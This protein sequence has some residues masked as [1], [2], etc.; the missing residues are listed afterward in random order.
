MRAFIAIEIPQEIKGF[1]AALQKGLR[2]SN[3]D[4]SWVKPH[5]IHVTMRF[6]GEIELLQQNAITKI[7][8]TVSKRHSSF[9][10]RLS[11][12][13]AFPNAKSPRVIWVGIDLGTEQLQKIAGELETAL[14]GSG[15]SPE[16]R[17]F[18]SHMTIGRTK[19]SLNRSLLVK[20]MENV[21][22]RFE[23][24]KPEMIVSKITLF[25]STLTPGGP[26]YEALY[27]ANLIT[28]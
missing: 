12:L 27:I 11:S 8:D 22:Q 24:E 16:E 4:I 25:K 3:A 28:T 23:E 21:N 26:V 9:K 15:F 1:L 19:S 6:L 2:R 18:T 7:L 10:L 14:Q 13:G 20:I 17:P 5:N